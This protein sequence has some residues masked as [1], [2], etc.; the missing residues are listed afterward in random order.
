MSK[1]LAEEAMSYFDECVS[2]STFD[3]SDFS[4]QEDPPINLIGATALVGNR[5]FLPQ[6]SSTAST[7][8]SHRSLKNKV[9]LFRLFIFVYM[10]S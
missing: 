3:S 1:C 4:S 5:A 9:H 8:D 10:T 7:T 2:I 6:G